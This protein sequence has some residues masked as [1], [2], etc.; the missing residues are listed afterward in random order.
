MEANLK[1]SGFMRPLLEFI[2]LLKC[3]KFNS[4]EEIV[5]DVKSRAHGKHKILL[6]NGSAQTKERLRLDGL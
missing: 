4:T 3:A 6:G 1:S 2:N 5:G